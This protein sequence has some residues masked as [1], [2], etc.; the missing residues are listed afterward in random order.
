M[1]RSKAVD[2]TDRSSRTAWRLP[3]LSA[4]ARG[5]SGKATGIVGSTAVGAA[6]LGLAGAPAEDS[7]SSRSSEDHDRQRLIRGWQRLNVKVTIV[8][9]P[10]AVV[11]PPRNDRQ[12]VVGER[13]ELDR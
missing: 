4:I 11:L 8:N 2:P 5:I 1:T 10:S 13:S 6:C 7:C 12:A 9:L 3:Q